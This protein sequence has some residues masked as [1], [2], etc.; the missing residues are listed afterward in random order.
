M[1]DSVF[2]ETEEKMKTAVKSVKAD[3]NTVRT[4]RA[5]PDMFES[6]EV[7]YYGNP[8]PLNQLAK[9]QIPEAK[10]VVIQPYDSDSIEDIEKA[11]MESDLG[12]TPNNDGNIIRIQIPDLTEE[13]REEL[14]DVVKEYCEEGKITLRKIRREG[15]DEIDLLEDE[16]EISEDAAHRARDE[17]QDLIDKYEDYL[18]DLLEKKTDE[19]MTV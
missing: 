18:D 7:D 15:R 13:R 17:V 9:I 5:T 1:L 8:T 3:F 4:G 10:Q 16:G 12:L 11:I 14:R 6:I 2:A 19:I